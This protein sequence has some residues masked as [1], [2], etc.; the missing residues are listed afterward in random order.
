MH[1]IVMIKHAIQYFLLYRHPIERGR[2]IS[3]KNLKLLINYFKKRLIEF[4]WF[5]KTYGCV[6]HTY[7]TGVTMT[8]LMSYG[9]TGRG[10]DGR[11]D[12]LHF[13]VGQGLLPSNSHFARQFC[14]FT[15][16]F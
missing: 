11:R 7:T 1:K 15:R 9:R 2:Q 5:K 8:N 10:E 14:C 16:Q 3:Y 6:L 12:T 13:A 4:K